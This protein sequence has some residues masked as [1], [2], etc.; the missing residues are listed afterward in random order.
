MAKIKFFCD[1]GADINSR[2]E[3]RVFDTV[4]NFG[5]DEG[6]WE[7]FTEDEK[8]GLAEEWRNDICVGVIEVE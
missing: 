7:S 4:K 6:Q 3:S 1:T 5:L 8:Q 2:C